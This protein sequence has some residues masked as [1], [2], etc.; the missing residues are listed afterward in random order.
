MDH[1]SPIPFAYLR[2]HA[3][4]ERPRHGCDVPG[5]TCTAGSLK[6]ILRLRLWGSV[7]RY[8]ASRVVIV[9]GIRCRD[10]FHGVVSPSILYFDSGACA[11]QL[12]R[13]G[14]LPERLPVPFYAD[15]RAAL[16][17]PCFQSWLF[18][19]SAAPSRTEP[20]LA[21]RTR[22]PRSRRRASSLALWSSRP[23]TRLNQ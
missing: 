22:S 8:N 18:P 11:M 12:S 4:H 23:P 13:P 2:K 9:S 16:S 6:G 17:C 21:R 15:A 7:K 3:S 5:A 20:I 19:A 14:R 10:T 1:T